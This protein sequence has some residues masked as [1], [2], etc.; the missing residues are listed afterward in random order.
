MRIAQGKK[1]VI[2]CKGCIKIIVI[3]DIFKALLNCVFSI[4][5]S[6]NLYVR[7]PIFVSKSELLYMQFGDF[8]TEHVFMHVQ[9]DVLAHTLVQLRSVTR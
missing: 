1:V 9:M 8:H 4:C 7:N 3:K 6:T 5:K 2:D